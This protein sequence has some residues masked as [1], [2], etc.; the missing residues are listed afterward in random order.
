MERCDMSL[1]K[2]LES[3]PKLNEQYLGRFHELLAEM[4]HV[5]SRNYMCGVCRNLYEQMLSAVHGL[6]AAGIVHRDIKPDNFLVNRPACSA[7]D[8]Q[9]HCAK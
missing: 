4:D 9:S 7:A 1:L 8:G 2:A 3:A 5:K 6:H